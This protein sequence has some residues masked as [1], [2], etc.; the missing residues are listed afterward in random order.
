MRLVNGRFLSS[1]AHPSGE[2][3]GPRAPLA[4]KAGCE[5][6]VEATSDTALPPRLPPAV[7]LSLVVEVPD[8]DGAGEL[9]VGAGDGVVVLGW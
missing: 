3:I 2:L 5:D 6:W 8:E 7:P 4:P 9:T 1:L